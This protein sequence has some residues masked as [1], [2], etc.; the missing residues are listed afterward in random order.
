MR[1]RSFNLMGLVVPIL[2][3]VLATKGQIQ[4]WVAILFILSNITLSV[5]FNR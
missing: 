3:I 5:K 1:I 2:A 4:W